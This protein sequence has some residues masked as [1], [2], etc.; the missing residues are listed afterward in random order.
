MR[1]DV[2]GMDYG[3][4]HNCAGPPP[5]IVLPNEVVEDTTPARSGF[6]PLHYFLEALRIAAWN[7]DAIQRASKDRDALVYGMAVWLISN[8]ISVLVL[9]ALS[10]AKHPLE[11]VP[12]MVGLIWFL[13]INAAF[14]LA[15]V[16]VCFLIAKWFMGGEGRFVEILRPLLLGSITLTLVAIPYA[17]VFLGAIAWICVFAMVFQAV[18]DIEAFSAFVLSIVVGLVFSALQSGL[19]GAPR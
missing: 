5:T 3:M 18:A 19:L 15:Q 13:T 11:L 2:C 4:T 12:T 16:G 6:L 7:G 1:C 9:E 14:S 17:G 8:S 10:P